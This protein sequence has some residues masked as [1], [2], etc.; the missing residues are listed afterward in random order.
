M[1]D[2]QAAPP[3]TREDLYEIN[4][5][6]HEV[7]T[8]MCVEGQTAIEIRDQSL[9]KLWTASKKVTIM[10]LGDDDTPAIKTREPI[11][12]QS[13]ANPKPLR[14]N[15]EPHTPEPAKPAFMQ[16]NRFWSSAPGEYIAG[17]Y[18]NGTMRS[19]EYG[20]R[21]LICW[22]W[23]GAFVFAIAD[24]ATGWSPSVPLWIRIV[25]VV[26]FMAIVARVTVSH[27]RRVRE[28]GRVYLIHNNEA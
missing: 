3:L 14:D 8:R 9:R 28:C 21:I 15:R 12:E 27:V 4:N 6:I 26:A 13:I 7:V 5:A 24:A 19:I 1:H 18:A 16:P 11:V 17:L 20:I 22:A 10:L 23:F 25:S 2:Q